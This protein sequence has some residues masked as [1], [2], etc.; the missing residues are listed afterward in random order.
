VPALLLAALV[1]AVLAIPSA[2]VAAGRRTPTLAPSNTVIDGPSAAIVGLDGLAVARDGTGGLVYVKDISGVAHVFVSALAGGRFQTPEQV[3]SGL[4]GKSSQPVIVADNGGL[5]LVGFINSGELYV[6]QEPATGAPWQSP[7]PI[8]AGAA[9]PSLSI[10]T[11]G[12]AYLA[13]TALGAVDTVRTAYYYNG[14]WAL[15]SAPLNAN[16]RESAGAGDDAPQVVTAGDGTAIVAWGEDDHIFTRRVLGTSP[17]VVYEQADPS[18]FGGWSEVSADD[19]Q[20]SAGGDSSYAAVAF[21]ETLQSGATEQTRVLVN[22]LQASQYDGATAADAG[23]TESADQPRVAL[24]EYGAGFVTAEGEQTHN[25]FT[26]TIADNAAPQGTAQANSAYEQAAP[27]AVPATAGTVSTLIAWQQNPGADGPEIRVRYAP[28]GSD[29]GA[30]EVVSSP[31]LG[32]TNADEGLF[33]G[34]DLAGDA[35]IAWVQGSGPQTQIV[36]AQLF[37]APGG[38]TPS[39]LFQ[40]ARTLNPVLSW[41]PASELW[42]SPVYTVKVG[43]VVVGQT[44]AT[45]LQ[46]PVALT[47]GRHVWQVT[48]TDLAGLTNIS[49]NSTVFVDTIAPHVTL[50]ITGTRQV[51]YVLH[52]TVTYTDAPHGLSHA[53]ASGVKTVQ[54]KWGDGSK[55]YIS[56]GAS[57]VYKRRRTYLVTVIAI[58]KAGNRTVVTR[59]LKIARAG[60][61]VH[62][63]NRKPRHR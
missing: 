43:G 16:P 32:P 47:Q 7:I 34:G 46:V 29:L 8:F 27:D 63:S 18:S 14:E 30:E 23:G 57:H 31:T 1:A 60:K 56:H 36:A 19:P 4:T 58:D 5:L 9:N 33:A 22:R 52:A 3:D 24:Q 40:Y 48:A 15:G 59:K 10:S 55:A 49:Q 12:K 28:D 44:T 25:V 26:T 17:S 51:G 62:S 35:A 50:R 6:V 21:D 53:D 41:S 37:Q 61:R 45:A 54:I 42:G 20:I 39:L 13:F 38:I 2:A 11:F